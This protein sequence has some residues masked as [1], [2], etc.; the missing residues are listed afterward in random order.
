MGHDARKPVFGV[1]N[2]A[3]F[4]QS[5]QLQRL[6]RKLKFHPEKFNIMLLSQK[7]ITKALIR[8]RRCTGWSAPLL[9]ANP[10]RQVFLRRGP[11]IIEK[12]TTCQMITWLEVNIKVTLMYADPFLYNR[13]HDMNNIEYVMLTLREPVR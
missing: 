10:C 13:M 9:F 6:A 3:S 8:L 11:I 1:S 4:I 5:P 2:K 7:R 12:K